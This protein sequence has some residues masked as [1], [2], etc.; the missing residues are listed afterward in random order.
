MINN[1]NLSVSSRISDQ[2]SFIGCP[3]YMPVELT[4][5]ISVY[6]NMLCF[7]IDYEKYDLYSLGVVA[8]ELI[9]FKLVC[10]DL[11]EVN[12]FYLFMSM[13]EIKTI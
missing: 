4:T 12:A 5:N 8:V 11:I 3:I 13:G 2:I 6:D 1:N 9:A 7:K 10:R